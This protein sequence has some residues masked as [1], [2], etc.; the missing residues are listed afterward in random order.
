MQDKRYGIGSVQGDGGTNLLC[1]VDH[2]TGMDPCQKVGYSI[3]TCVIGDHYLLICLS[4]LRKL[5]TIFSSSY[6]RMKEGGA[7]IY[8]VLR[9]CILVC[10]L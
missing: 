7:Q 8:G 1:T 10:L 3:D 2:I 6:I 4:L 5:V 9:Y